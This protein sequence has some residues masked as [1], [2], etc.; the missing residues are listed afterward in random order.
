MGESY[1]HFRCCSRFRTAHRL[2]LVV[3]FDGDG[4]AEHA[5]V[6]IDDDDD[7]YGDAVVA[8]GFDCYCS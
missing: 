3:A 6:V 2:A 4:D 8:K 5:T 7:V 1:F